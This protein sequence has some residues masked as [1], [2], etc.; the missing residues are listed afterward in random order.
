MLQLGLAGYL[1]PAC[2]IGQE[3]LEVGL[4]RGVPQSRYGRPGA[5]G[6]S[7][8][9]QY[10]QTSRGNSMHTH[11][12]C[13]EHVLNAVKSHGVHLLPANVT[14]TFARIDLSPGQPAQTRSSDSRVG[15]E[16]PIDRTDCPIEKSYVVRRDEQSIKNEL[17]DIR[18]DSTGSCQVY[19]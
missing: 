12:S 16:G 4:A 5:S 6:G 11:A 10:G 18:P 9:L 3:R 19:G 14:V 13:H 17:T 2:W 8:C 15:G 1:T 7:W